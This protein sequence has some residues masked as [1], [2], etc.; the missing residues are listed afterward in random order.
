ML[1]GSIA[2]D[3]KTKNATKW[4]FKPE[5]WVYTVFLWLTHLN[6]DEV[7]WFEIIGGAAAPVDNVLVLAFTAQLAIP[8]GDAQVI[9]HQGVTHMTVPQ[10]RMEERLEKKRGSKYNISAAQ[11]SKT[12]RVKLRFLTHRL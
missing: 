8:V 6:P 3:E 9:V 7:L 2:V 1:D 11:C 10:H 4:D 12:K 5:L